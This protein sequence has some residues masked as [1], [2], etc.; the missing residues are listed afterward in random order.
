MNDHI[1]YRNKTEGLG[2]MVSL[3]IA[4]EFRFDFCLT[5]EKMSRALEL[6]NLKR[7]GTE[8]CNKRAVLAVYNKID[9]PLLTET[10]FYRD[11]DY[12]KSRDGYWDGNHTSIQLEDC[13]DF[14][15]A[16]F[17]KADYLLVFELDY[18]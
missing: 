13:V 9:K 6:V 11:F 2:T 10:L 7:R 8:Y 14:F 1:Y 16:I 17:N 3:I 12:S 15:Y 4:R 18:S 5:P